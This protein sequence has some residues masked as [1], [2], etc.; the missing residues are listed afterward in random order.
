MRPTVSQQLD[1]H[2]ADDYARTMLDGV[3]NALAVLSETWEAVP[4]FLHWDS[5]ATAAVLTLAGQPSPQPPA[6]PFDISALEEHHRAVRELLERAMP[7][8]AAN[9]NARNAAVA[10]FRER[11]TRFTQPKLKWAEMIVEAPC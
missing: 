6:D 1:D 11:A 8:I 10:L 9:D 4:A 5:I 2:V 3:V 7:I